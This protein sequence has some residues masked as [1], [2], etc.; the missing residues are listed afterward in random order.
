VNPKFCDLTGYRHEELIGKNPRLL[1][2]GYTTTQ[3]YST[4]YE[5]IRNG[6][7]WKGVFRNVKKNGEFF[8]ENATI[9]PIFG[10]DGNIQHYLGLKEDITEKITLQEQLQH[11]QKMEAMGRLAGGISHDFNNILT[12]IMGT[13][14]LLQHDMIE[15]STRDSLSEIIK[16]SNRAAGLT[17][18]LL[19]FSKKQLLKPKLVNLNNVIDEMENM[20]RRILPENIQLDIQ[21]HNQPITIKVDKVQLEQVILNLVINAKEAMSDG[22]ELKIS[23]FVNSKH[24]GNQLKYFG[25]LSIAD[26]GVGM[27]DQTKLRLFEPFFTTKTKGTGLGLATVYG[28]I[29]QS[30]GEIEV[31]SEVGLGSKFLI[32]FPLRLNA[33]NE[34]EEA[35]I[36]KSE[37][38]GTE[39][40]LLIEDEEAVRKIINQILT[41]EGYS[42]WEAEN[43]QSAILNY[44][45]LTEKIDLIV[46]DVIMPV[47]GGVEV[48]S[49][50]HEIDST[51]KVLFIS[52]YA[53]DENTVKNQDAFITKP[54]ERI[55]LLKKIR[56]ILGSH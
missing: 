24:I 38:K 33:V 16:A 8:W 12:V 52:G 2:S 14:Q 27:D 37:W 46:S 31:D 19:A 50:F 41:K 25:C 5:T 22:G 21:L 23:S 54:I 4:L 43:G 7:I 51:L 13:A 42:V 35:I 48:V 55:Q 56:E 10:S 3:E 34:E 36:K 30:N 18:Q 44:S 29:S 32:Y 9:S 26:S 47:M 40:I 1:K 49:K 6:D 28:I 20:I 17:R 45:H 15:D 39:T 53:G 11:S